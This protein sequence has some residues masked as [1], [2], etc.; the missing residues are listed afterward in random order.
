MRLTEGA[1]YIWNPLAVGSK[2]I[3]LRASYV[4]TTATSKQTKQTQN[5][6]STNEDTQELDKGC[7]GVRGCSY[8]AS[9]Q[10]G[11]EDDERA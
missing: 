9:S 10:P 1:M 3:R 4:R 8:T 5:K 11:T 7:V 6:T 2:M